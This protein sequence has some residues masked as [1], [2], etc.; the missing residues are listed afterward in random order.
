MA[1][2]RE[3]VNKMVAEWQGVTLNAYANPD[4]QRAHYETTGPEIWAA[5]QGRVTHVVCGMGATGTLMGI[6]QYLKEQN[7]KV[8]IIGVEPAAAEHSP[9]LQSRELSMMLRRYDESRIDG[10]EPVH[11]A[12]AEYMARRLAVEEGIFCGISSGAACE[13]A[14]R[15]S[16]EVEKATIVFMVCD[17]GDRYLSMGMF[18][19]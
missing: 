3:L 16:Q 7:E 1:F 15:L 12:H 5:T 6:S 14:V 10:I 11:Q 17:R 13:V 2:A 8:Q 4:N 9:G 18:P 19:A